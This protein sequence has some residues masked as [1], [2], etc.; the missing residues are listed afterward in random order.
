MALSHTVGSVE[1]LQDQVK[2]SVLT[3]DHPE[4]EKVRR[5]WDL[6]IDHHP[7]LII[8][9]SNAQDV[10]AGVRYAR[11]AGLGVA[12]QSTGHGMQYPADDSLL[13][14]TSQMSKVQV[15]VE[16]RTAKIESG[17]IWQQVLDAV[18][19]HGLAP[20]LGS[21]PHVGV[22]GY[23]LGGG[24]G[25]LARRYGL[26]ADSVRAVDI[27]TADGVL[28]HT[29]PTENSDLFWG[30]RG[31][32]GNF[33]V[34][35]ALEIQLYPVA[36]VY[37]GTLTYPGDLAGDALRFYRDW[38]KTVPDELTSSIRIMKFPALPQLP[39]AMRG[40]IVV[41]VQAAFVGSA[42][43]GEAWIRPWL[44]WNQP[45]SNTFHEIPFS[46][47]GTISNDPVD[48]AAVFGSNEMLDNLSDDAIDVIVRYATDS[49]SPF[50]LNELRHAG[51]A[52][53]RVAVDSNAIGNR[54]A[55][56][57]FQIGGPV[58]S[59]E[60]YTAMQAYLPRYKDAM[61]PYLRGGVY[62][63]F[64]KGKEARTRVRDA[65]RPES[66]EQLLALKAKYDPDNVF[67]FSYQIV[68]A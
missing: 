31:G 13:I 11:E 25:W 67:R 62:L 43:Q 18:T 37:G 44:D 60:V 39:E 29:S 3:P 10:V 42:A 49:T 65:Y 2:G 54:D 56:L 36:A 53:S 58:F 33:G 14:V 47:I 15:D 9:P 30:L 50:A 7:A 57:F 17:A 52:I 63:N 40:K 55:Q 8:V 1:Q 61:K 16:A 51:G 20:L 45:T 34:V 41:T 4:Y 32:G 22:V 5:S 48:P 38:I 66:Y 28:R 35:T 64:M 24:I 26:A 19:L 68:E 21:S 23:S 6:S 59:P 12:V 27:V 46:E